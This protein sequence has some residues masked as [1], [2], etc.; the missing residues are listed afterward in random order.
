MKR[1][2][3]IGLTTLGVLLL[4]AVGGL[5]LIKHEINKGVEKWSSTA[6]A[7]HPKAKDELT[8]ML[9]YLQSEEHSLQERNHMIWAIGQSRNTEALPIL[10]VYCN[11]Y[12]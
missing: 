12:H 11:F 8:A 1:R 6:I 10:R 2:Y 4:C 5:A 3:R 9:T 7:A